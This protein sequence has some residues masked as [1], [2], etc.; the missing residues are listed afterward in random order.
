MV[1]RHLDRGEECGLTLIEVVVA[2][3]LI[4]LMAIGVFSAYT[5]AFLADRSSSETVQ[6]NNY[7]HQVMETVKAT[8]F[9]QLMTLNE[10]T[11]ADGLLSSQI[12]VTLVSSGLVRVEVLV[13]HSE[14][15][16]QNTLV[17]TAISR[18]D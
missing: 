7:A 10:N 18:L 11:T 5:V 12:G 16:G 17:V 2:G 9:D 15:P 1:Q 13:T 14:T 6:R 3:A 8:P 4:T